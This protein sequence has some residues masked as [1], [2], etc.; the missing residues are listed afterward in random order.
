[1]G[2][3]WFAFGERIHAHVRAD[4]CRVFLPDKAFSDS[5]SSCSALRLEMLSGIGP[6]EI[7]ERPRNEHSIP[8]F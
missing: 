4:E 2:R 7:G 1:M 8:G 3:G 6:A 5:T